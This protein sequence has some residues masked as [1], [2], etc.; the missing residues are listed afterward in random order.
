MVL[1]G[2]LVSY[3]QEE[4]KPGLRHRRLHHHVRGDPGG[5]VCVVSTSCLDHVHTNED[6]TYYLCLVFSIQAFVVFNIY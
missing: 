5:F 6:S 2:S 3:G 1:V 4:I